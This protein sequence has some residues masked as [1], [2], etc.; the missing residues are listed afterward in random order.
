MFTIVPS[1]FRIGYTILSEKMSFIKSVKVIKIIIKKLVNKI[2][3]LN[4]LLQKVT[5]VLE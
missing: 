1:G 4:I 5:K 3:E 2:I